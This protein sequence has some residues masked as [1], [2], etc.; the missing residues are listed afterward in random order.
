MIKKTNAGALHLIQLHKALSG[1][2]QEA[3]DVI[4]NARQAVKVAKGEPGKTPQKG[5]DYLTPAEIKV[6][7]DY[8]VSRIKIP[9]DG[10]KGEP[11]KDGMVDMDALA[12]K[13]L[14]KIPPPIP[15]KDA[16]VNIDAIIKQ[17]ASRPKGKR[18]KLS[19]IDGWQ[20][21]EEKFL[22]TVRRTGQA[23]LHGGGD[24]VVAGTNI[25][26]LPG[27]NGTKIINSSGGSSGGGLTE[28]T[29]TGLVNSSNQVFTF[30]TLPTY[31]VA[32]GLWF[33]AKDSNGNNQ[34][35]N[36]GTTVTMVNPPSYSIYGILSTVAPATP[37]K[38]G[39]TTQPSGAADGLVFG[40]QPVIAI[41]DAS[42]NTVTSSTASVTA[43]IASGSGVLS[44]TTTVTA[45]AGVATFTNL[46]ITGAG[47]DT[48]IFTSTGLTSATSNNI[49]VAQVATQVVITTQP[50]STATSGVALSQQPILEIRDAANNKVTSS[51][52]SVTASIA[53]GTG[54]IGGTLTIAA[55]AGVV[56]FTNLQITG[57][58][59]DTIGFASA[60]LTGAT[61][62][63]ITVSGAATPAKLGMVVQPANTNAGG[64][65]FSTQPQVE[66]QDSGGARVTSSTATVTVTITTGTGTLVGTTSVAA[67]A[68]LV[69]FT[70]LAITGNDTN[71]LTFASSGLTSIASAS[72]GNG[73]IAL[74]M[75]ALG[76][77][78]NAPAL[79][80]ARFNTTTSGATMTAW[81]DAITVG[82]A[83]QLTNTNT[84]AWD[85]T[86]KIVSTNG[87]NSY[88]SGAVNSI[89]DFTTTGGSILVGSSF[90]T[91][92]GG[93]GA[94]TVTDN[95]TKWHGLAVTG[96]Q[97]IAYTSTQGS[98]A[99][100]AALSATRRLGIATYSQSGFFGAGV[101]PTGAGV[102]GGIWG[103]F[104]PNL[105][106][107]FQ[108]ASGGGSLASGSFGLQVGQLFGAQFTVLH[109]RFILIL[110]HP[111][112]G[113]DM[114]AISAW[115]KANHSI[116]ED[117]TASRLILFPGDSRTFGTNSSPGNGTSDYPTYLMGSTGF[118]TNFSQANL[119]YP[120]ATGAQGLTSVPTRIA[121]AIQGTAATKK[122]VVDAYDH[123][124][125]I[126]GTPSASAIMANC[127]ARA[128]LAKAAGATAC[129]IATVYASS[130][131]NSFGTNSVRLALNALK[132]NPANWG[133]VIDAC[134]DF[135][136]IITSP[137]DPVLMSGDGVHAS[138]AG[139]QALATDATNGMNVTVTPFI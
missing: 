84:V 123:N 87:T 97:V 29:A 10:D 85:S 16:V 65:V 60:G 76:G 7:A 45:V 26:I 83:P 42:G 21:T 6:F 133:G 77:A 62:T 92:G 120:S 90:P 86:N 108:S 49:V 55:V 36:S 14:K 82:R 71:I 79:Y 134:S 37:S 27:P 41:Q 106:W 132:M 126:V 113:S 57:A 102:L 101:I 47:T 95:N 33:K 64:A 137:T 115:A 50:S 75:I 28:L 69:T 107:N 119:G 138:A 12:A 2:L 94:L 111:P 91:N 54:T 61:S 3:N 110:A 25:T 17:I 13:I 117:T 129:I 128:S 89:F 59:T 34:W 63:S 80:D 109:I 1:K 112:T 96:G 51:T 53:S 35:T 8:L 58:S 39:I 23:Y 15:G 70:N 125:L 114:A 43:A 56:T 116:V 122:I 9:K 5:I 139:N 4:A 46:K 93:Q 72:F 68:G 73:D 40:T 18:L 32:D 130:T 131:I 44:G 105:N 74:M 100:P 118:T 19:E 81:D 38:L 104:G 30:T 48:I 88:L 121:A 52:A 98:I 24:T 124:D 136:A 11:G 135:A 67:V 22:D 127:V 78:T 66:I 103:N 20:E 99:S 31:I